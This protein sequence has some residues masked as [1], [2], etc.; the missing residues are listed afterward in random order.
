MSALAK[1]V[2]LWFVAKWASVAPGQFSGLQR[3]SCR[4]SWHLIIRE[5]PLLLSSKRCIADDIESWDLCCLCWS[6]L[7]DRAG[8]HASE[9]LRV[10]AERFVSDNSPACGTRLQGNYSKY[11]TK[12]KHTRHEQARRHRQALLM[13][14][15]MIPK[16]LFTSHPRGGATC[17]SVTY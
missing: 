16:Q 4:P 13:W 6:A 17:S 15:N 8:R 12:G 1:T 10:S 5:S 7:F 2:F 11:K 9:I 3:S 14:N